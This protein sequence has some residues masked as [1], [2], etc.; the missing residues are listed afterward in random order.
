[1]LL[2]WSATT[3]ER[4]CVLGI[5][6]RKR[7]GRETR[8][9]VEL[10]AFGTNGNPHRQTVPLGSC[11]RASAREPA[12]RTRHLL[13]SVLTT[14]DAREHTIARRELLAA[15]RYGGPQ[16]HRLSRAKAL[17]RRSASQM[18]ATSESSRLA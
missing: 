8:R 12:R 3:I 2:A 13:Q 7:G 4:I 11:H 9:R 18:S 14:A 17:L 6:R 1:M 15:E 5:E 10:S 16:G